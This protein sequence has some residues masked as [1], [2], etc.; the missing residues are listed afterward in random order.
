VDSALKRFVDEQVL[1]T[2][3]R[4]R[5]SGKASTPSCATWRRRTR[6]CWPNAIACS[7]NWTPGTRRTPARSRHGRLPR[8]PRED[9]LPRAGPARA[10]ATT[11]NVD[12]ELAL[13]A[14][15]QLVVP[16]LNARYA[17]NAANAR[18]GSAVRRAVRHRRDPG[19]RRRRQGPGL[20]RSARRQGHRIRARQV[21]DQ[22]APLAKGSHAD[23]TGYKVKAA[24]WSCS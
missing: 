18:W 16:I 10:K 14:G 23:S 24:S 5:L 2:V 1:P 8:L 13:Q 15:P 12:A 11:T 7:P 19:R 17:L 21:L 20:Q 3:W 22:A 4:R 9:R 6:R